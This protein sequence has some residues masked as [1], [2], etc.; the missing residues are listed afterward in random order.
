MGAT[1]TSARR[2]EDEDNDDLALNSEDTPLLQGR[3]SKSSCRCSCADRNRI[4]LMTFATLI[5]LA[6]VGLNFVALLSYFPPNSYLGY[7]SIAWTVGTADT[8]A[9]KREFYMGMKGV[10]FTNAT[11]GQEA[12]MTWGSVD[13]SYIDLTACE[14]CKSTAQE[15]LKTAF[16]GLLFSILAIT[17]DITRSRAN[18]DNV[19]LKI[20]GLLTGVFRILSFV[21]A[22][23]IWYNDCHRILP[24]INANGEPMRFHIGP[25]I[26]FL[27]LGSILIF[28]DFIL[29]TCVPLPLRKRRFVKRPRKAGTKR[30]T[31]GP[32]DTELDMLESDKRTLYYK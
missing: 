29:H 7:K 25:G 18:I 12:F 28:I 6:S 26:A 15:S 8:D 11:T 10:A 17:A 4:L 31:R 32:S 24:H 3:S 21:Y 2:G 23:G 1:S 30:S 22:T 27:V 9:G 5:T 14:K 19:C 16:A 13:C 20:K